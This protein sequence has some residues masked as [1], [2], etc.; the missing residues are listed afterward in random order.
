MNKKGF[1]LIEMSIVLII[2]GLLTSGIVGGT[3]LIE[4]AR[5]RAVINEVKDIQTSFFTFWGING[6]VLGDIDNDGI[7]GECN[8]SMC[9]ISKQ[10]NSTKF[11]GEYYGKS[12]CHQVGPWV[13]LY[14]NDLSTFK[15]NP[16]SN[17][18]GTTQGSCL[19]VGN[20]RPKFKS[21]KNSCVKDFRTMIDDSGFKYLLDVM[22]IDWNKGFDIDFLNKLRNKIDNGNLNNGNILLSECDTQK[23]R[24]FF[25]VIYKM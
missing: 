12:V 6:R 17:Y 10:A 1:S 14:L 7:I 25:Y 11:G 4:S 13:D 23:C 9:P 21:V 3:S 22:S 18:L 2:I 19:D 5:I 8:G 16:N 15:P 20:T 24:E